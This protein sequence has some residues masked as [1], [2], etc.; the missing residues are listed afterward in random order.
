[1]RGDPETEFPTDLFIEI[2]EL[3]IW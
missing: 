1:M 2:D 3:L